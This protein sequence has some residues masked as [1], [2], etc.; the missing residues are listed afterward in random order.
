MFENEEKTSV[1]INDGINNNSQNSQ[2]DNFYEDFDENIKKEKKEF[3]NNKQKEIEDLKQIKIVCPKCKHFP[4]IEFKNNNKI[5]IKCNCTETSFLNIREFKRIYMTKR[6]IV[7]LCKKHNQKFISYCCDC[8]QDICKKCIE[9][10]EH[11]NQTIQYYIID[12]RIIEAIKKAIDD[13]IK[14]R[15]EEMK[16]NSN[17]QKKTNPDDECV[18]EILIVLINY[19]NYDPNSIDSIEISCK[20]F[21]D[22]I[23]NA[24]N[25]LD[26]FI[27]HRNEKY[28][29]INNAN[30]IMTK[31]KKI[32]NSRI[33]INTI[34]QEP[35]LIGQL[36]IIDISEQN[37]YDLRIFEGKHFTS[38][39]VL[40]LEE[41]NIYKIDSLMK[42]DTF[43]LLDEFSLARNKI[44]DDELFK[45]I[46]KFNSQFPKLAFFN[47]YGNYLTD[48]NI[49]KKFGKLKL[50]KLYIG[51]NRFEKNAIDEDIF[52]PNLDKEFGASNGVFNKKTIKY[53]SHLKFENLE[54][55][56]LQGNGLDSL[57]FLQYL[58]CKNL[59]VL[60]LYKNYIQ[61]YKSIL[62][63]KEKYKNMEDINLKYNKINNIDDIKDFVAKFPNFKFLY[64]SGNP[65]NLDYFEQN[66]KKKEIKQ[67]NDKLYLEL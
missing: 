59:K 27:N 1:S 58:N 13:F 11:Q 56:Y 51:A 48:Y 17:E 52:F 67:I 24:Y 31:E 9:T 15:D 61:E 12:N 43:D 64:L 26:D 44:D 16:K 50:R 3:E 37:F 66:A 55:I 10:N 65:I 33:D 39:T 21:M 19:Y 4:L 35:Y 47:I 41:N 6:D 7:I 23:N 22:T 42:A 45:H 49:F 25:F 62:E 32:I 14:K 53:L 5:Y 60:W 28:N 40:K 63:Y 8:K 2:N 18:I 34:E 57:D 46:D 20:N 30:D 36:V 29:D 54:E 38:L